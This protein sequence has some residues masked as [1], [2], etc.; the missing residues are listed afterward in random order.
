MT[1]LL[2]SVSPLV[3]NYKLVRSRSQTTTRRTI[4]LCFILKVSTSW[5]SGIQFLAIVGPYQLP[6]YF[7]GLI[8]RQEL[9]RQ[10]L[11]CIA[12]RAI[13]HTS[14]L[15][16]WHIGQ[17]SKGLVTTTNSTLRGWTKVLPA[18]RTAVLVQ[19]IKRI[20]SVDH[21]KSRPSIAPART[22]HHGLGRK[23]QDIPY[24]LIATPRK[25]PPN[26]RRHSG[27]IGRGHARATQPVVRIARIRA[28][29]I[30]TGCHEFQL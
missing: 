9:Q 4:V 7:V 27:Y 12:R 3:V 29:N 30:H 23:C 16:S 17:V 26:Q 13:R 14:L 2:Y 21:A 1:R 6:R 24:L 20:L 22:R 19:Q 11:T 28:H 18:S 8:I 10:P 25:V 5:R 15:E